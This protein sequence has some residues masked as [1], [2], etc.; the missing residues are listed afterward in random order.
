MCTY[1]CFGSAPIAGA[2][3]QLSL[4][5]SCI[6]LLG[7]GTTAGLRPHLLELVITALSGDS[8]RSASLQ[9]REFR[10]NRDCIPIRISEHFENEVTMLSTRGFADVNL[11]WI[12]RVPPGCFRW[13]FLA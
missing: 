3:T 11:C 13:S 8:Y 12:A 1:S 9:T 4:L 6:V 7:T 5:L 10:L 2:A